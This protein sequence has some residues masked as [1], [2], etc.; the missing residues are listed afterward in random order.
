MRELREWK[1]LDRQQI[2]QV[3]DGKYLTVESHKLE[4]PNGTVI[5]NWPWLITPE[6]VNVVARTAA[7]EFICFRQTKYACRGVT[8][9][10]VGGYL[11]PAEQPLAAAKRELLEETGYCA[12]NWI[13]LGSYAIDGNRGAG[14]SHLFVADQA[15]WQQ[16][17]T[18]DDLEEQQ[19]LLLSRAEL[20]QALVAG[21][22]QVLPWS[23]A[24]A[25]AL[26]VLPDESLP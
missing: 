17:T 26:V 22:F 24:V 15:V 6:F 3:D 20:Q 10:V 21:E 16:P 8:M 2:L 19:L 14:R 11:D 13:S 7:G 9:A 12:A 4:L 1:T 23:A 5:E 25:M 18:N